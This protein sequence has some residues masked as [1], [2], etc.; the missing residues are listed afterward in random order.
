MSLDNNE[1][2]NIH[3]HVRNILSGISGEAENFFTPLTAQTGS[4]TNYGHLYHLIVVAECVEGHMHR[5][6][7]SPQRFLEIFAGMH[8]QGYFTNFQAAGMFRSGQ[9]LAVA[10]IEKRL[11]EE[12]QAND[13]LKTLIDKVQA[14][15]DRV[16]IENSHLQVENDCLRREV[17]R[18]KDGQEQPGETALDFRPPNKPQGKFKNYLKKLLGE[19]GN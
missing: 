18:L 1:P 19:A 17:A 10:D 11:S 8:A 6:A 14:L 2:R 7:F 13:G 3:D 15:A 4:P 12:E 16:Q 9:Q 5:M